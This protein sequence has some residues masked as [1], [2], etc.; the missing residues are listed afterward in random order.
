[1]TTYVVTSSNYNNPAF[2]SSISEAGTGH[3]LDLSTLP[4]GYEFSIN[5]TTHTISIWNGASW[6]TVGESGAGGTNANLGA[7]TQMSYFTTVRGSGGDDF[8][9]G[10]G[11]DDVLYSF[12]GDDTIDGGG[13]NDVVYAGDGADSVA[14]GT[15]QDTLYG[16]AGNDTIDGEAGNDVIYAGSGDD[17]ILGGSGNDTMYGEDGQDTF[18]FEDG[19]GSDL[20]YGGDGG[21]DFDIVDLSALSGAATVN[22][23]FSE[24]GTFTNGA[25]SATFYQIEGFTL[26]DHND[27]LNASASSTGVWV[28]AGQGDDRLIGSAGNDTL[29]GGA[30]NDS[31]TGGSGEDQFVLS[32]SGGRDTVTDF[33][34]ADSDANG[35]YNDQIDVSD[36][37]GGSGP[38]GLVTT[39][40]VV[41][42]DDGFGNALLTFPGGEQLV[43]QGV[44]PGQI[45]SLS[46]L[47][48]AGIPCFTPG[49]RIATARGA[50]PVEA[51]RVGDLLQTA[52]H[53]LQPVIW[54]GRRDLSAAEL[55]ARPE[56]RPIRLAPGGSL[57]NPRGL[58]VS[59]QHRFVLARDQL[60]D[61][62]VRGE[63]FVRARLLSQQAPGLVAV[64]QAILEVSYIH[65]MTERHEVI[66]AEG[67]ATETFW[68]GPEALRGLSPADRGEL[69]QLFPELSVAQ[70]LG[71]A[72]GRYVVG[73]RYGA[74]A[75]QD[76][77]R[78]D[79]PA[80]ARLSKASAPAPW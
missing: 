14:G 75:R 13:G 55:R 49:I 50:V 33:D 40:D 30:G 41:V 39:A 65:L 52:D 8:V 18:V 68:P 66:F 25:D 48:S 36:L 31:M 26:T 23:A 62:S 15:G 4:A 27:S 60:G 78:A 59:P 10:S 21:A 64:D 77:R 32:T 58:L 19:F 35:F 57:G 47:Y 37:V 76:L 43:L 9:E 42:G 24:Y 28:D 79:L 1:M 74:L 73:Q 38:G 20:L 67:V 5:S 16:Q 7:P 34:L 46:Q 2:W 17:R 56:L 53:G 61:L 70:G 54:T 3:T 22:Y 63:A 6:Y 29:I 12:A 44:A 80:L 72:L 45:S 51:I 11:N 69:F 71:G